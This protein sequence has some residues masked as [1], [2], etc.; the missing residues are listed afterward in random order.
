MSRM[1]DKTLLKKRSNY[2]K[3]IIEKKNNTSKTVKQLSRK[4]FLSESTIYKDL[5]K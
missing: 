1:R 2:V 4:L 3:K 5:A